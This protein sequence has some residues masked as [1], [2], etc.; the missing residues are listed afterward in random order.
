MLKKFHQLAVRAEDVILLHQQA[1]HEAHGLSVG[2]YNE[3]EAILRCKDGR[4]IPDPGNGDNPPQ[5]VANE[6]ANV[7][8]YVVNRKS[9]VR[10]GCYYTCSDSCIRF[11]TYA[12]CEHSLAVAELDGSLSA[13][14]KCYKA[15][16]QRAPNVADLVSIDLPAGRGTKKTKATQ[17]TAKRCPQQETERSGGFLYKPVVFGKYR[18][19]YSKRLCAS[20]FLQ[21]ARA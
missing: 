18:N 17:A 20:A 9:S 13:F 4:I 2:M 1:T 10:H 5:Y 7:P 3:A 14:F 16:N 11:T 21:V 15:M 19:R 6:T 8:A 12:I